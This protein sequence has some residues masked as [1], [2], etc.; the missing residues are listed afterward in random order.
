MRFKVGVGLLILYPLMWLFAAVVPLLP[1]ATGAKA[2]VIAGD[3]AAAEIIALLGIACVGKETY[4]AI[5][6]RFGRKK[7]HRR[8]RGELI[9]SHA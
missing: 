8:T 3:L 4:Q 5:K 1:L 9:S 7:A 2:A 6:A